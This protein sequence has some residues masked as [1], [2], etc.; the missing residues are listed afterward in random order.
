MNSCPHC[1]GNNSVKYGFN[2]NSK[3]KKSQKR[4][5][6]SCNKFFCYSDRFPF[7]R[8]NAEM[9]SLCIDLYLKGLSYRIIQR[10]I[11]EQFDARLS[12]VTLY[13]W[14]Q[15]YSIKICSYI[16]TLHPRVSAVWQM[17]ET[18][19]M[20]KGEKFGK[21]YA[22]SNGYWCWIAIDTKTRFVLDMYLGFR[23]TLESGEVFFQRIKNSVSVDP[24][25]VCTDGNITYLTCLRKYFPDAVHVPL[26]HIT[27][28]PNTSLIERFNG[29]VKSRIKVMRGFDGFFPCQQTLSLFQVYYNFLRPHMA[30]DGRTPAQVAGLDLRLDGR[31]VS[32]IR[33]ASS[34]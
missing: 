25:V 24:K 21:K 30:L 29:T 3:G 15:V 13:N 16:S 18:F 1:S 11:W 6:L 32:L 33:L 22:N 34:Y 20:H 26:E 10:Q 19:I 2:Y 17:D 9:I 8:V 31:W 27:L 12:H 14:L 28:E 5:C 7:G 23:R 4:K